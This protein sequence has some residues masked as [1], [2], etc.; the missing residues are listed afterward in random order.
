MPLVHGWDSGKIWG[1]AIGSL[2]W[3]GGGSGR[4]PVSRRRSQP[5][6]S[7]ARPHAHLGLGGGRSW[8]REVAGVGARRGPAAVAVADRLR[9]WD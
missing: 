5:G 3:G 9:Q 1:L 7:G 4:I 6:G 2:A 8:G